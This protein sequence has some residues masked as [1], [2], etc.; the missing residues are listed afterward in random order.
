M[1]IME[2]VKKPRLIIYKMG[3]KGWIK[4]FDDETYLKLCI[5]P[6]WEKGWT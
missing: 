1:N 6:R 3:I 5:G 2:L 4:G